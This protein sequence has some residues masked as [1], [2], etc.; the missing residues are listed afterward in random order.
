M[1]QNG[2][3]VFEAFP[4][5]C[6]AGAFAGEA[7]GDEINAPRVRFP[8]PY[9]APRFRSSLL[10]GV[11]SSLTS[12]SSDGRTGVAEGVGSKRTSDSS[13]V[14]IDNGSGESCSQ[15]VTSPRVGLAEPSVAPSGEAEPGVEQSGSGEQ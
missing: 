7:A 6:G 15:E 5:A 2:L 14:V 12:P 8:L 1:P 10:V 4:F 3:G 9:V 11:G 13:H